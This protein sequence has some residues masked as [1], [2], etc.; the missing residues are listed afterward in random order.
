MKI[1]RLDHLVLTVRDHAR[2]CDFYTRGLGMT[3]VTFGEGRTALSFGR[4]KINLHIAGR[5]W[6]PKAARPLP[7]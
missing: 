6:E 3:L 4:Q 7:G 1:D 5:E 2:T